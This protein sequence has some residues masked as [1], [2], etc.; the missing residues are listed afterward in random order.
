M[1]VPSWSTGRLWLMRLAYYKFH[2]PKMQANDWAW[3]VDH[4][5]QIGPEKCLLILGIRL[6]DL[7]CDRAL[8]YEDV[9]AIDLVPVK[10]SNG[11]IVHAQLEEAAKKMGCIPREIISDGGSDIKMGVR[12]FC[13]NHS[14]TSDIY[15]IVHKAAIVLKHELKEDTQWIS[16]VKKCAKTKI[17][18]QQTA[19]AC[20][21]PPQQ[22]SKSRYMNIDTLVHWGMDMLCLLDNPHKVAERGL[23]TKRVQRKFQWI[24]FFHPFLLELQEMLSV[25]GITAH[26][27][28]TQ[29]LS[30]DTLAQLKKEFESLGV[31]ARAMKAQQALITFINQESQKA[32]SGER[33]LGSSEIIESV[34]G[35]QKIL[36]REQSKSGFTEL[37][38]GIGAY[39]STTTEEVVIKAMESTQTK[40]ITEWAKENIGNSLQSDRKALFNYSKKSEQKWDQLDAVNY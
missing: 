13:D 26:V 28:R 23:D 33:L 38:L 11:K 17:Q 3:I 37:V 32:K 25:T 4:S 9:E 8:K 29:G 20:L 10:Q 27:V 36:E 5:V 19:L 24:K 6:K 40:T 18:V 22:R 16:F 15:D 2:R 12:L 39:V 30:S 34:F 21:A 1:D 7:P 14:E 31:G 35:K